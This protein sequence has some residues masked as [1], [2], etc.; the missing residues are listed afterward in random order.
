MSCDINV[1]MLIF[2][3]FNFYHIFQIL[4]LHIHLHI[5][6]AYTYP[7]YIWNPNIRKI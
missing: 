7:I 2:L 5:P 3:K 6:D 1:Y 4:E